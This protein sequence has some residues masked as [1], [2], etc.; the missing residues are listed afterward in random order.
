MSRG[1][2]V[3]FKEGPSGAYLHARHFR[4]EIA[5]IVQV[6][7][8][9]APGELTEIVVTEG[10]RAGAGLHPKDRAFDIRANHL[11]RPVVLAWVERIRGRLGGDYD[12]LAH[13]NGANHHIHAE[14]D[15]PLYDLP[16]T[17]RA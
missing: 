11:P 10:W 13:G 3:R 8:A 17:T 16:E 15:P 1:V 4:P 2:R 6:A 7:A 9:E 12:V 5:R 14:Y